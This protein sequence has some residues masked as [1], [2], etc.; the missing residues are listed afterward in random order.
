M[1]EGGEGEEKEPEAA[2]VLPEPPDAE[3][4][5]SVNPELSSAAVYPYVTS[6]SRCSDSLHQKPLGE[7]PRPSSHP[8][9]RR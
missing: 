6:L 1:R 9:M 3:V 8:S 5:L 4:P 7:P 2:G